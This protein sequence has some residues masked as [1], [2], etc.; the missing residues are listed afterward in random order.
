MVDK[1][2]FLHDLAVVAI[3]KDEG[4]YLKEWLDYHLLAGVDH[5]YLYDNE[6]TDNQAEVA[7][8]YV[9]AGLVDYFPAPGEAMQYAVYNDAVK[10]FKFFNRYMAF[11]DSDEFIY[12]KLTKWGGVIDVVDEILPRDEN[13]AGLAMHY[14]YFGSNGQ[15]KADYSRGVLE[16]FTRRAPNDW[17]VNKLIKTIADPRK[18]KFFWDPH[19]MSY[20]EPFH[21][22]DENLKIATD[23]KPLPVLTEK[24]VVNHYYTKSKEE[25]IKTK[26]QRGW[27]C[28][29]RNPYGDERFNERDRNEE[30]DDGILKYRA[31]R[32]QN[33]SLENDVERF[34]RVTEALMETLSAYASGK[35]FSIETA[36]ICRALSTYLRERFPNDAEYW[37][38][39]EETSLKAIL[40][41]L[42][43]ELN[44]AEANLFVRELPE[45]LR[46][47]HP[48]I[49]EI[50]IAGQQIIS[51]LM[52]IA[53]VRANWLHYTELDCFRE[54]LKE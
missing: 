19:T 2:L 28:A 42:G 4:H 24:I 32:A 12:P 38:I 37:K 20:F 18:I 52:N 41:S 5:F 23:S 10:R 14:H 11:I 21:T 1:N 31:A 27:A 26:V 49:K 33:F 16:R 22:V 6:S 39:C 47:S 46:L 48:V 29:V 51:Q 8:P 15:E 53:R 17:E 9:D 44:L 30:F 54:F 43:S 7:K 36:L 40:Q 34:N 45:L 35:K 25:Y 13:A 3:L 50:R